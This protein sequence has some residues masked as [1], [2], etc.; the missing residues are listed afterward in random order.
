MIYASNFFVRLIGSFRF[1]LIVL[2]IAAIAILI[3]FAIPLSRFNTNDIVPKL[4]GGDVTDLER[5]QIRQFSVKADTGL[6]IKNFTVFDPIRDEFVM[7]CVVWFEFDASS[8]MP[9]IVEKFSFDNG[10]ILYKSP[11]DVKV[12]GDKVFVKYDVRVSFKA[13]LVYTQFPLNDHR[14]T[15]ILTNDFV[16]PEEMYFQVDES[17]FDMSPDIKLH[18]WEVT[19]LEVETGH[20]KVHLDK[21]DPAKQASH[22]KVHFTI[23]VKKAS[24][25]RILIIFIPFFTAAFFALF[26]FLMSLA[27]TRGRFSLA[28]TSI[29]ALLGYRFVIERM[30]PEVGYFTTTDSIYT[31]LLVFAFFCF[32]FQLIITRFYF[33]AEND[34]RNGK[35]KAEEFNKGD[36]KL[37]LVSDIT[38]ILL[39]IIFIGFNGWLLIG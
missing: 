11:P 33:I 35:I 28:I 2:I 9:D 8:L 4:E 32:L 26:S 23:N 20:T 24:I 14:V 25:R 13:S 34:F 10:S 38:F 6:F 37:N 31:L 18:N 3:F 29:T 39:I 12:V 1:K 36:L 22:P 17:G 15:I 19:D 7:D 5:L 30:M 16:N 21:N 27:N